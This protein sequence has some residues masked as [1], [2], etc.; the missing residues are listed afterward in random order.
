M[1]RDLLGRVDSFDPEFCGSKAEHR[2]IGSGGFFVA[3]GEAAELLEAVD[4]S[5]D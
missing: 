4:A 3:G 1:A 5:L 2:K